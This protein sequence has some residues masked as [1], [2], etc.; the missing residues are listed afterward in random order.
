M[1]KLQC[2][3]VDYMIVYLTCNFSEKNLVIVFKIGHGRLNI[4]ICK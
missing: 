1:Y 4:F 3:K 2:L